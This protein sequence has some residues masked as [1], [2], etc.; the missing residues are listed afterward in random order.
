MEGAA[1]NNDFYL[2]SSQRGVL[3]PGGQEGQEATVECIWEGAFFNHS[4]DCFGTRKEALTQSIAQ[5]PERRGASLPT[6]NEEEEEEEELELGLSVCLFVFNLTDFS[7]RFQAS[8]VASSWTVIRAS[9]W[10]F[11]FFYFILVIIPLPPHPPHP[12]T[13]SPSLPGRG[14]GEVGLITL[15]AAAPPS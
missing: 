4:L 14:G 1:F 3:L 5:R 9:P 15:E 11:F 7:Q 10:Y 8:R 13:S 2:L 12:H 6:N